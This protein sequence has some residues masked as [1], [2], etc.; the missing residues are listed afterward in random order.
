MGIGFN[1]KLI[2]TGGNSHPSHAIPQ[3]NFCSFTQGLPFNLQHLTPIST[4][5]IN[6]GR[7]TDQLAGIELLVIG[8]CQLPS[9]GIDRATGKLHR[10]WPVAYPAVAAPVHEATDA[11]NGKTNEHGRHNEVSDGEHRQTPPPTG[12]DGGEQ[13]SDKRPID[14]D[15]SLRRI[16]DTRHCRHQIIGLE[17]LPVLDDIINSRTDNPGNEH[18][19]GKTQ[20]FIGL[21]SH[22]TRTASRESNPGNRGQ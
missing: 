14:D 10:H 6:T 21:D 2:E 20:N 4:P 17:L 13:T 1:F 12:H 5:D 15:S 7:Q 3:L 9:V 22:L 16:Y 19:E 11:P 8:W 18:R